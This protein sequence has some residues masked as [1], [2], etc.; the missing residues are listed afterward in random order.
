M[1][2]LMNVILSKIG[3]RW[4]W[5]VSCVLLGL[6]ILGFAAAFPFIFTIQEY[7]LSIKFYI[8][9]LQG[10][11]LGAVMLTLGLI[12]SPSTGLGAPYIENWLSRKTTKK[13]IRIFLPL[14]IIV[15]IGSSFTLIIMQVIVSVLSISLGGDI[16]TVASGSVDFLGSYPEIWKWL[17]V[18]FHAGVT[19]ELIFRFGLM[20]F[21]VYLGYKLVFNNKGNSLQKRVIWSS[22]FISALAFG[23]LHLVGVLPVPDDLI[24]QVNVVVQNLLVGLVFGWFFWEFG[25]VSAMFTHF[26][27]DVF[28]YVVMMP[29]LMTSNLAAILSWL[30]ITVITLIIALREYS[31]KRKSLG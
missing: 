25:L 31:R 18:S 9:L 10:F 24:S 15:V 23:A 22:N 7:T 21:F 6:Y 26:L 28:F 19:E 5:K 2:M 4:N 11:L 27:L 14:R 1:E 29:V 3:L 16:P 8:E 12:L 13:T 17:L 30:I 20:N